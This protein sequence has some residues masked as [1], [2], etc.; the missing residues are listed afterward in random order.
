MHYILDIGS[1]ANSARGQAI[2]ARIALL[3]EL[4]EFHV[5]SMPA[6]QYRELLQRELGPYVKWAEPA[7]PDGSP[8]SLQ[9]MR[10]AYHTLTRGGWA[11]MLEYL[12]SQHLLPSSA[13]VL[14]LDEMPTSLQLDVILDYV[15]ACRR[16]D[17]TKKRI[18]K[19]ASI[20]TKELARNPR[21]LAETWG[22]QEHCANRT[23]NPNNATDRRRF[24]DENG[25]EPEDFP[26]SLAQQVWRYRK[27][28]RPKS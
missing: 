1:P 15:E 23:P 24:T 20:L 2:L 17:Y 14:A 13:P 9:E 7:E 12:A 3:C 8:P 28:G 19:V 4:H 16:G 22:W 25:L 27:P 18:G 11:P 10:E 26:P 21:T 5:G 6:E